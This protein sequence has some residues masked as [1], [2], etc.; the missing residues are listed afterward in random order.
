M[1]KRF[2]RL[3]FMLVLVAV[4]TFS[5]AVAGSPQARAAVTVYGVVRTLAAD[6]VDRSTNP[7]VS[8]G[9]SED[10]YQQRLVVGNKSY[11]LKG[12]KAPNNAKVRVRGDIQGSTFNVTS[13]STDGTVAGISQS[14]TTRVLTMLAY[15][16]APDA[17]T[18]TTAASQLFSDTN[19]WYR[20]A[21]Y[22]VLGQTGDVTP[23]MQISGPT[24]GCYADSADLMSQAKAA[25]AGLGYSESNYDNF[26]LYFPYC[27]GDSS[28]FAGWA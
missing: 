22:G 4:I 7:T 3:I 10:I 27:A 23:W 18:Q 25:A 8:K 17:V 26:V 14:G 16:T 11:V 28:G 9:H 2:S 6:T 19:G 20:D 15:W 13:I 21:S 5:A 1:L 24:T 12:R